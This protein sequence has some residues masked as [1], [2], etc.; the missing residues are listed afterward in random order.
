M[1][2]GDL[3]GVYPRALS[4][5]RAHVPAT[6]RERR[7]RLGGLS[8]ANRGTGQSGLR[9]VWPR[10]AQRRC[11]TDAND[12]RHGAAAAVAG[13]EQWTAVV[14]GQTDTVTVTRSRD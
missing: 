8:E 12:R 7:L 6:F 9:Q 14:P 2:Q 13:L 10:P 3:S 11:S 1:L 4:G 5:A